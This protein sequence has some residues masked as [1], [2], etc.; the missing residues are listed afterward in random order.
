MLERDELYAAV[1]ELEPDQRIVVMLRFW[2]DLTVDDIAD[3]LGVPPGTVK[4]RLHRSMVRLRAA[5]EAL[6]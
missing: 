4:S 6:G 3:R 2:L 5:L 1:A